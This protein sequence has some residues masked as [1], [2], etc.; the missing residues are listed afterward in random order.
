MFKW[1]LSN[2]QFLDLNLKIKVE[3]KKNKI[4]V[5]VRDGLEFL[6][7]LT[8]LAVIMI[9]KK[10]KNQTPHPCCFKF[11]WI[12]HK[13]RFDGCLANIMQHKTNSTIC[14]TIVH[15][16]SIHLSELP[17]LSTTSVK[18][19]WFK[20]LSIGCVFWGDLAAASLI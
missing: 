7:F 3:V 9:C 8:M 2:M 6:P 13:I 5:K 20:V 15:I 17:S 4:R 18:Y 11:I 19:I 1:K 12:S 10:K 16:N 14:F